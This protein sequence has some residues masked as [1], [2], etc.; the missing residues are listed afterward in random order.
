MRYI[1]SILSILCAGFLAP[2][3]APVMAGEAPSRHDVGS[4]LIP[5]VIY[6]DPEFYVDP[7]WVSAEAAETADGAIDWDLLGDKAHR[8]F[9]YQSIQ[10]RLRKKAG[11]SNGVD[12]FCSAP[13]TVVYENAHVDLRNPPT[14]SD[15]DLFLEKETSW[16]GLARVLGRSPGFFEGI[17]GTLLALQARHVFKGT[18]PDSVFYLHYPV[19]KLQV[20]S[21]RFCVSSPELPKRVEVGEDILLLAHDGPLPAEVQLYAHWHGEISVFAQH[22]IRFLPAFLKNWLG[23]SPD[24]NDRREPK[25]VLERLDTWK[26][27]HPSTGGPG[28]AQ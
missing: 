24:G 1:L 10:T 2:L 13:Q 28:V 8:A 6:G 3:A 15:V 9:E 17:P 18:E 5:D 19:A 27:G 22:E 23:H 14:L 21:Q 7:V 12:P 11:G 26:E 4:H 16:V 20:G 25:A